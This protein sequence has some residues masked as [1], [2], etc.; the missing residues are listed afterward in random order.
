MGYIYHAL[1]KVN[2]NDL[3]V[4]WDC[5]SQHE[6]LDACIETPNLALSDLVSTSKGSTVCSVLAGHTWAACWN[7][8]WPF[9]QLLSI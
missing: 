2:A 3:P 5:S 8:H 1:G 4:T 9:R 7:N 6:K